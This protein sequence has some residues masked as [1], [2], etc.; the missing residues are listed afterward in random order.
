METLARGFGGL[1][2]NAKIDQRVAR[3]SILRMVALATMA[4]Y[5]LNAIQGRPTD[6]RPIVNGRVN[7]NFM[8]VRV[9][10]RDV[11][12]FGS[13]DTIPRLIMT[14]AAGAVAATD[15]LIKEMNKPVD[16]RQKL[17]SVTAGV[18]KELDPIFRSGR[19]LS[20][21][22]VSMAWDNI[23]REDFL[24]RPVNFAADPIGWAA[25][26]LRSFTPFATEEVPEAIGQITQGVREGSPAGLA[27]GASTILL[28]STGAKSSPLGFTDVAD[29]VARELG[30]SDFYRDAEPHE[31]RKIRLD[32][33]VEEMKNKGRSSKFF[34]DLEAITDNKNEKYQS[35][36][37]WINGP[38][39]PGGLRAF[40]GGRQRTALVNAYY[41]FEREEH[42]ERRGV[43]RAHNRSFESNIRNEQDAALD[44]WHNLGE[45]A[46]DT[47][48]RFDSSKLETIRQQFMEN[49]RA[50]KPELAEYVLRNIYHNLNDLPPEII[51]ALSETAT[52]AK[53][54]TAT[55]RLMRWFTASEDARVEHHNRTVSNLIE[56]R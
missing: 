25:W 6:P 14:T 3:R 16:A 2:P 50:N 5:G 9:L 13:F 46:V 43:E 22:A 38:D 52:I 49:L 11:S 21:G 10:G 33:R 28:E 7:P 15:T 8:K 36:I 27:S 40:R 20:S 12:F 48:G 45:Q 24:G 18:F 54:D 42:F 30:V 23:Q 32:P 19:G 31:R 4:T 17:E 37:A 53:D 56:A 44:E 41:R 34:K 55:K 29:D 47:N 35:E 39:F 51:K 26:L 1:R